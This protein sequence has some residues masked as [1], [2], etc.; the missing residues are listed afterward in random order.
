[1]KFDFHQLVVLVYEATGLSL[2]LTTHSKAFG[3]FRPLIVRQHLTVSK[4]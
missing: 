4:A 1:M 3:T 2:Q